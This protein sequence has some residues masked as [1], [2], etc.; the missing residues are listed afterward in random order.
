VRINVAL[1]GDVAVEGNATGLVSS[2]VEQY[3]VVDINDTSDDDNDQD[4]T[5]VSF[6]V[7][8]N[9]QDVEVLGLQGNGGSTLTFTNIPWGAVNPTILFEGDGFG[10]WDQLPKAAGNPNQSNVGTIVA[11]YFFP[12]APANVLITN[13]GVAPGLTSTGEERPIVI[14]GIE[15]TN[16]QSLNITVEDGNGVI[17][18]I[19]GDANLED[20]TLTSANDVTLHL[21]GDDL[22]SIDATAVD[23]VATLH[24][25][26]DTDFS[27]TELSGIDAV[28][29]E[30]VVI[31]TMTIDQITDIGAANITVENEGD[32]ATLNIGNYDGQLFDF[33]AL[34]LDGITVASV[35]FA[36]GIDVT[37]DAGTDFTGVTQLIIPQNTT[38]VMSAEQFKQLVESGATIV[39]D[40]AATVGDEAGALT[41][42]LNGD[43]TIGAADETTI[44]GAN[45]TFATADGETLN[46]ADFTLA[47]GLQVTGDATAAT[48]PLV[49]FTFDTDED[50]AVR[51]DET[52]DVAAY[53]DVDLR[54]LDSLLNNF[55]IDANANSVEDAGENSQSIE[56]LLDNLA[57]ANILNIYQEEA[58]VVVL[59]PRD[60]EVVVEPNAIVNGIEFSAVG[61]L[62]DYVRSIDLTLQ[63]NAT[64]SATIN[65][66]ITVNDADVEAGFTILTINA[67]DVGGA[68]AP[69][70][71]NGDIL[72][73]AAEA[74]AEG[75]L[76]S[77]VINANTD[78]T[79]NGTLVFNSLVDGSTA[80]L[81]L[82]GAGD[83][84]ISAL[85]ATDVDIDTLNIVNNATGVVNVPGASPAT[86]LAAGGAGDVSNI[87]I[88]GTGDTLNFGTADDAATP[89]V[90][91]SN[92]GVNAIDLASINAA[93]YEGDLNL[94]IITG[95]VGESLTITGSQGI[96]TLTL[97]DAADAG[98]PTTA[99]TMDATD[100][101]TIDLSGSA[102][103][104]A[105]TITSDAVLPDMT[106]EAA[107]TA[108]SL[109]ISGALVIEGNVDFR[110]L[111]DV[112]GN[113]KLDLS[114]VTGIELAAGASVQLTDDQWADL[115]PAQQA[116]IAGA[117]VTL[118]VT[119]ADAADFHDGTSVN[120]TD[121]R[122]TTA[123]QVQE[124]LTGNLVVT[125]AQATT[126]TTGTFDADG[127]FTA[128]QWDHDSTGTTADIARVAGDFRG[129]TN[130]FTN[131][132][133]VMVEG[134]AQDTSELLG[135]DSIRIIESGEA[136]T[137]LTVSEEQVAVLATG[138]D[139]VVT[140]AAAGD[141]IEELSNL[142]IAVSVDTGNTDIEGNP[143]IVDSSFS[144][145][146]DGLGNADII[147]ATGNAAAIGT[148]QL[149]ASAIAVNDLLNEAATVTWNAVGTTATMKLAAG[150]ATDLTAAVGYDTF[151]FAATLDTDTSS[152]LTIADFKAS[153]TDVIN[154]A[155]LEDAAGTVIESV[156]SGDDNLFALTADAVYLLA[157]G[158][159]A[160]AATVAG[161]ISADADGTTEL[162][163][164]ETAYFFMT[165]GATTAIYQYTEEGVAD[166]QDTELTLIGTIDAA[167]VA[168][169]IVLA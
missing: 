151:I 30:N 102:A 69:V 15:T 23:G 32:A 92:S 168:A 17:S 119:D 79:I 61:A 118:A 96:T 88:S 12:G 43:L 155:A 127:V 139:T 115:T 89:L 35:T 128:S 160:D 26:N 68:A 20:V 47:D 63:A 21:D 85:D 74:G 49:N 103:G 147:N 109:T 65:G 53:Q 40:P 149:G 137:A 8:D 50:A 57:S 123:I 126:I 163:V 59:D 122:G 28:V 16:A 19:I 133:F 142:T 14:D 83:I 66:G 44:A 93:G 6:H 11:E 113:N 39:T 136:D 84:T 87:V 110:T 165:T 55:W 56:D 130:G 156:D 141:V 29:L 82:N 162:A 131:N 159:N 4:A 107:A 71:I 146:N 78:I 33:S 143:L 111:V 116:A 106:A 164:G 70:V 81:T 150:I 75:E 2:G 104:S 138:T 95:T 91:E 41:V 135:V 114:G 64:D 100:D 80:T 7:C 154:F 90:N 134:A 54:I 42:D 38:V 145:T 99:F 86:T 5:T 45:V 27:D 24:I 22:D 144:I 51:F 1:E 140:S 108:G 37:V 52:I 46:V 97:G 98:A 120:L 77:V 62:A 166:V 34:A 48:K 73:D 124:D 58:V 31:V 167:L 125:E 112:D 10:N 25:E 13:Q 9:T 105:V 3:V 94:G 72:S 169:D 152:Q 153:G 129:F 117:G 76:T 132:V 60:R 148:A 158:N 101:V 121:V 67:E 18:S 161:E 36:E 157:S